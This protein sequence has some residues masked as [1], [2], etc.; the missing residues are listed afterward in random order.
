MLTTLSDNFDGLTLNLPEEEDCCD[1]G[2]FATEL[3]LND[4]SSAKLLSSASECDDP[5]GLRMPFNR[6]RSIELRLNPYNLKISSGFLGTESYT[7]S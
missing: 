4:A 1:A 7:K 3:S 2:D 5:D 6:G